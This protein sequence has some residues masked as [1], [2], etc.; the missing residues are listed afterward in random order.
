M[1]I[2]LFLFNHST[3]ILLVSISM[4][5]ICF[6][7]TLLTS[8]ISFLCTYINM[9]CVINNLYVINFNISFFNSKHFYDKIFLHP[10]SLQSFLCDQFKGTKK[11]N[12]G[13]FF[14]LNLRSS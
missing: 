4:L 7:L 9:K 3:L 1:K 14:C 12:M 13:V 11:E 10:Y 2:N 8:D 6:I 5:T